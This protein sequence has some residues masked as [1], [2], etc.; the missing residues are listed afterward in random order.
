MA[1]RVWTIWTPGGMVGMIY[2]GDQQ[3]LLYT[4]SLMVIDE[5]IFKVFPIICL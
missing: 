4:V 3:T 1:F 2:V 5:K